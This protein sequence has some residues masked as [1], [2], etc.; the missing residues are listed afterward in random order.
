MQKEQCASTKSTAPSN[1]APWRSGTI[2]GKTWVFWTR[3][4]AKSR[5]GAVMSESGSDSEDSGRGAAA[6]TGGHVFYHASHCGHDYDSCDESCSESEG[7][8]EV[9]RI[10]S[11]G[12]QQQQARV[13]PGACRGLPAGG[14]CLRARMLAVRVPRGVWLVLAGS[15]AYNTREY[16]VVVCALLVHFSSLVRLVVCDLLVCHKYILLVV[17]V[18]CPLGRKSPTARNCARLTS[19]CGF[20]SCTRKENA[21]DLICAGGHRSAASCRGHVLHVCPERNDPIC[22]AR[23]LQDCLCAGCRGRRQERC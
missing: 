10:L 21:F 17:H 2:P 1:K 12:V 22:G 8:A 18:C 14:R 15:L 3:A 19:C 16:P 5:G 9:A 4:H 11:A 20:D 13:C 23:P 6:A 7:E